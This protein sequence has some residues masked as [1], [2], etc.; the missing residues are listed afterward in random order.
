MNPGGA[1]D[2]YDQETLYE[3]LNIFLSILAF[4][5]HACEECLYIWH[6]RDM[7]SVS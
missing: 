4:C 6:L 5:V 1:G 3:I 2:G 7:I